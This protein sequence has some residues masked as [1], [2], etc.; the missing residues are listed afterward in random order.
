MRLCEHGRERLLLTVKG[1]KFADEVEEGLR[2]CHARVRR[3]IAVMAGNEC[4]AQG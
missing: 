1:G 4:A 2:Q 3:Q